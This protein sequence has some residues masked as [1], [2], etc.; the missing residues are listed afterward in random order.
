[1]QLQTTEGHGTRN[2]IQDA[3]VVELL[4]TAIER[5]AV[6][7]DAVDLLDLILAVRPSSLGKQ[8]MDGRISTTGYV[9]DSELVDETAIQRVLEACLASQFAL[10]AERELAGLTALQVMADYGLE[11]RLEFRALRIRALGYASNVHALRLYVK[12]QS[13]ISELGELEKFEL[14]LAYAR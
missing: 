7:E 6:W 12:A 9:A 2:V 13:A 11:D 4:A 3:A 14:G 10:T 8:Y 5:Q 1:M